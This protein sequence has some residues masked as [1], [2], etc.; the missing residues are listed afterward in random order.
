MACERTSK[1]V[2]KLA[3]KQW[4]YGRTAKERSVAASAV[5]ARGRSDGRS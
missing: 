4:R 3:A 1:R 2:A 5:R